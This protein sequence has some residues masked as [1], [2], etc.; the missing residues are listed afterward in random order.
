MTDRERF[1]AT[2]EYKERDRAPFR[3]FGAWPETKERW[4]LE[5]YDP[6]NPPFEFDHWEKLSG[7]FDPNPPF[8]HKVI[9]EDEETVL[10]VNHEGILMRE[11]KNNPLSSMPQFI[12]FPVDTR[13]DFKTFWK[14]RMQP[15]MSIRMGVDWL[16]KLKAFQ[17][18]D[19]PLIVNVG[20][21]GGFF[22]P[23]R[24][25]F[26]VEK[27]CMLFYDDP[28]FVEEV[29][30]AFADYMILI[31]DQVLENT[32]I[33]AFLLWEDM[34]YKNGPLIGPELARKFML[35]RYRRVVDFLHSKGVKYIV[36]DSDGDIM[37]LIPMWLDAGINVLYPFEVQCG[38]DVNKVRKEF[39]KD[40]RMWYGMDKRAASKGTEAID[41]EVGRI[42]QLIAEGGYVPGPDHAFPPDVS[43]KNYCTFMEKLYQ[44]L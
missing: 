38:M 39:G 24:N 44:V 3:D 4:K 43:F 5:G 20:R 6:A 33:D 1:I 9:E 37:K 23:L 22:G 16:D 15:N 36:L 32:D 42:G 34:A 31:M 11:R 17:D 28:A 2:M 19:F 21:W 25:L 10:Y 12:K 8:E 27:L 29:M 40:L 13:N 26:G 14:E 30:D 7:I 18:R 41:K 35:P